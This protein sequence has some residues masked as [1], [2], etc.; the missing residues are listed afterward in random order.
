[1]LLV[2]STLVPS[3]I[4]F[5]GPLYTAVAVIAGVV[6]LWY[7]WALFRTRETVAMKKAGRSLFTYSLSYLSL[8]FLALIADHV[9]G[10]LGWL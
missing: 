2:A 9:A 1:M 8:I 5:M 10:M 7:A 6:F 4:G 3:F